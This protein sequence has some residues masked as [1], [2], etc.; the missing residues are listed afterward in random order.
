MTAVPVPP[1]ERDEDVAV[2]LV[3]IDALVEAV[4]R[5]HQA[6]TRLL[7]RAEASFPPPVERRTP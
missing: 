3:V 7:S 1:I 2:A 6:L 4:R 5:E